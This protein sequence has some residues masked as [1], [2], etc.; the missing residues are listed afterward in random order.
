MSKV[1]GKNKYLEKIVQMLISINQGT[2][3]QISII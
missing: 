1:N 2:V 3:L